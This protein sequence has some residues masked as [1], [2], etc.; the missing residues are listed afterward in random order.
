M[1]ITSADCVEAIKRSPFFATAGVRSAKRRSKRKVGATIV[2]VFEVGTSAGIRYAR[3]IEENGKL[4]VYPT[5]AAV[6]AREEAAPDEEQID[7]ERF[8]QMLKKEEPEPEDD[9]DV[10]RFREI[11]R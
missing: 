10:A 7:A 2:R 11:G 1:K 3:V 9:I 4:I 5:D 6:A 8:Q